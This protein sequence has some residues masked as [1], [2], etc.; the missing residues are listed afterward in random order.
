MPALGS[1]CSELVLTTA[2]AAEVAS[3]TVE[4]ATVNRSCNVNWCTI[5]RSTIEA[6]PKTATV[7]KAAT[8]ADSAI[9][10]AKSAVEAAVSSAVVQT[11]ASAPE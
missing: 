1:F 4:T 8:V 6:R 2:S 7:A 10:T 9:E 5:D 3:T 11:N